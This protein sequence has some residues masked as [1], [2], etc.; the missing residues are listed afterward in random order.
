MRPCLTKLKTRLLTRLAIAEH[1]PVDARR[2][3]QAALDCFTSIGWQRGLTPVLALLGLLNYGEGDYES[4]TRLLG[5]SLSLAR[6][7]DADW[8]SCAA[9][10]SLA[11]IAV[12][13]GDIQHAADGLADALDL[14]Q[15]VGDT[16]SIASSLTSCARLAAARAD[17]ELMLRLASAADRISRVSQ[18]RGPL[19]LSRSKRRSFSS[20]CQPLAT[21]SAPAALPPFGILDLDSAVR[22]ARRLCD[23]VRLA[24]PGANT[25]E[26]IRGGL[27]TRETE[28]LRLL[29]DGKTNRQIASALVLSDKTVTRHVSNIFDTLGV[30]SPAAATAFA[31]R[32][33]L[34]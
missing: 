4:A 27:S 33:G 17:D 29:A 32:G 16:E 8:W 18:V 2:F 6:K 14:A 13:R 15:P 34:A 22:E 21:A 19:E 26:S 31:L 9:L 3:E 24:L 30:S 23:A 5:R 20:D 10:T 11:S 1:S 28:V 7:L 25:G 12:D